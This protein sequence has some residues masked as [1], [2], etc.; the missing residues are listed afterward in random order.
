MTLNNL[1]TLYDETTRFS[2]AE[3]SYTEALGKYRKLAVTNPAAYLPYVATTLNNLGALY[4]ETTRFSDAEKSYR[5][6]FGIRRKLAET[7]PTA[8]L[9]DVAD[10]LYNLGVLEISNQD[11]TNACTHIREALEIRDKLALE[12][13]DAFDLDLCQT[14]L[15]MIILYASAPGTCTPGDTNIPALVLQAHQILKKYPDAPQAQNLLKI[16]EQLKKALEKAPENN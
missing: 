6:A 3:T 2:D 13:P 15:T 16:L 12:N 1:G 7:N 8:Y 4:D 10:T 9:P 5:E 11:Y 14:I